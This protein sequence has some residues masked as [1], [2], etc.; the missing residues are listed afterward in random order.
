MDDGAF[1]GHGFVPRDLSSL[2]DDVSYAIALTRQYLQTI[3]SLGVPQGGA[4]LELGPGGDFAPMLALASAGF[5]CAVADPY[6]APWEPTYHSAMYTAFCD[7][8]DGATDAVRRVLAQGGYQGVIDTWAS[9]AEHVPEA[10]DAQFDLV[11]SHAAL[12]HVRDFPAVATELARITKPGGAGAHQIDFRHHLD[13][14]RPLEFLLMSEADFQQ[15]F[16]IEAGATGNRWRIDEVRALFERIGFDL[17]DGEENTL[18]TD[19]YMADFIPRLKASG[20]R[21][22]LIREDRLKVVGARLMFRR[23]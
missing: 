10:P 20:S 16:A 22:S 1:S 13:F 17:V 2:A 12:E 4:I 14:E 6:L 23:R 19:A 5:Q 7:A 15:R 3:E 11:L 18:A 8:F 21:F 9:P